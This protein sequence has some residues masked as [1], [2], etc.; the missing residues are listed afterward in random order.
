[1]TIGRAALYLI[2]AALAT[3]CNFAA[4]AACV[5]VWPWSYSIPAS[6]LVGT[7]A[8]LV[9]KYLLDKRYIFR[10]ETT[11]LGHDGRL[12][13]LYGLMSVATT[14]VFWSSE[15][16]FGAI[17][18][19]EAMRYVGGGI[20]LLVGYLVKYRLDRRFVFRATISADETDRSADP[21]LALRSRD[22]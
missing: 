6:V 3:A 11:G 14:A 9:V 4:Q 1:M 15:F 8:G 20:G 17:F 5:R 12:F 16:V 22:D 10:F 7:L 18:G 21:A 13:V 19:T 2:F